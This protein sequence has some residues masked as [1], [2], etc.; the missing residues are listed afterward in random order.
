MP[1]Y[2]NNWI[3]RLSKNKIFWLFCLTIIVHGF[4]LLMDGMYW[5]DFLLVDK[6]SYADFSK[7]SGFFDGAGVILNLAA[8]LHWGVKLLF[9]NNFIFGCRV[10]TVSLLFINAVL[11]YKISSKFNYFGELGAFFIAALFLTYPPF[12]I[13]SLMILWPAFLCL[14]VF[15]LAI[16]LST[17]EK[18]VILESIAV[19]KRVLILIMF[20]FSFL[21]N[22]LLVF[23]YG[24]LALTL[25]HYTKKRAKLMDNLFNFIVKYWGFIILPFVFYIIKITV[26][27]T[28]A[29]FEGY[30]RLFISS[31]YEVRHA[32]NCFGV[33]LYHSIT[34]LMALSSNLY[35]NLILLSLILL[36]GW[37]LWEK[38]KINKVSSK[39]VKVLLWGF[40]LLLLSVFPYAAV[41][42]SVNPA[43]IY[44]YRHLILASIPAA[45]IIY[46]LVQ[47]FSNMCRFPRYIINAIYCF[48]I[49]TF[50]SSIVGAYLSIQLLWIKD[51]AIIARLSDYHSAK[52]FS[53]F[54]IDMPA[55]IHDH[56]WYEWGHIFKYAW[57]ERRWIGYGRP[58]WLEGRVKVN[59]DFNNYFNLP[60]YDPHGAQ[61]ELIIQ[62]PSYSFRQKTAILAKYY[63]YKFWPTD[64]QPR[65]QFLKSLVSIEI[66]PKS[67]KKLK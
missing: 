59:R 16:Y 42:D 67:N 45:L 24:F 20:A 35:V 63:R 30:N 6:L 62:Y 12:K 48:L 9:G 51:Q 33:N 49:I 22:S 56:F 5:D 34:P 7:I 55:E 47:I 3:V 4:L 65:D 23:Y 11:V 8:S 60:E 64:D 18:A 21:L 19:W 58:R 2:L 29:I 46:V 27:P 50:S 52:R 1:D 25:F 43:K 38:N 57:G 36:V 26:Y 32:I 17:K 37:K 28:H 44:T 40:F 66:R 10:F 14:S 15:L 41:G 39:D 53:T 54:Y 31:N 61:A 13:A